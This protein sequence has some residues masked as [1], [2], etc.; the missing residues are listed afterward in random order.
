MEYKLVTLS[1]TKFRAM[2]LVVSYTKC[3][4][5]GVVVDNLSRVEKPAFWF[6]VDG[7]W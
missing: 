4:A 2:G 5:M 3:L 1:Y 6:V 7:N